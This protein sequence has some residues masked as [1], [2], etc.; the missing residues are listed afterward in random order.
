MLLVIDIGNTSI[1]TGVFKAR[2][3]RKAFRI[4]THTKELRSQYAKRL[5]PYLKGLEGVAIVSVVP[6]VL[7]RVERQIKK[8]AKAKILVVGRDVE[9]GVKNLYRKPWQVGQDRLVNARAAY[10]IYGGASIVVDFGTAITI[11]VINKDREYLAP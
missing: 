8:L 2:T 10:E 7:R 3:L 9:A 11:D 1:H 5:R 6:T 4:P